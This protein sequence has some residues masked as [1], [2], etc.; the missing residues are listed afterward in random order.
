MD[1][2]LD[3]FLIMLTGLQDEFT[4]ENAEALFEQIYDE[5]EI[6]V[7]RRLMPLDQAEKVLDQP[8]DVAAQFV[9]VLVKA[10]WQSE[11]DTP[12]DRPKLRYTRGR[13]PMSIALEKNRDGEYDAVSIIIKKQL[14]ILIYFESALGQLLGMLTTAQDKLDENDYLEFFEQVARVYPQIFIIDGGE[15]KLL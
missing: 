12:A 6:E 4:E 2:D 3:G 8:V 15:P 7:D 5:F 10:G 14:G 13:L 11:R 9:E 1:D